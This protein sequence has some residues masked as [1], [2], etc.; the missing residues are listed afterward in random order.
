MTRDLIVAL[1]PYM[2]VSYLMTGL[3]AA[4]V[5]EVVRARWWVTLQVATVASETAVL[6]I[7]LWHLRPC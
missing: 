4:A 5:G 2:I 7:L 6:G 3:L 1:A